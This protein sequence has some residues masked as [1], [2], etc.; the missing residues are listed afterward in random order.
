MHN[1]RA[2][3]NEKRSAETKE[4]IL[5]SA[6]VLFKD[7]GFENTSVESI[8]KRAGLSKGSFYVHFNSKDEIIAYFINA[9]ISKIDMDLDSIVNSSQDDISVTDTLL[10]ILGKVS[11][12]KVDELG[13]PLNKNAAMIYNKAL[14]R[15]VFKLITL[16]MER[17]EFNTTYSAEDITSDFVTTIRGFIFE[18]I[19]NYPD[20]DLNHS[21]QK[22]FKIY[23]AGLRS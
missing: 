1:K 14:Y 22:H 21:L 17:G 18:W 9:V 8:V 7:Q 19:A 23:L 16:G 5:K 10:K 15:T 20:L 3:N 4:K 6:E 13:Y 11:F 2:L 12:N